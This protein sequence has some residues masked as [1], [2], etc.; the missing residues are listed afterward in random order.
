MV[1]HIQYRVQTHYLFWYHRNISAPI[2]ANL[3]CTHVIVQLVVLCQWNTHWI[4]HDVLCYIIVGEIVHNRLNLS[5]PMLRGPWQQ[6][7]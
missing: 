5:N 7:E 4:N 2:L 3:H 1:H 6:C